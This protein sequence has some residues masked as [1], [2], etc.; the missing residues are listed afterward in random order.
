MLPTSLYGGPGTVE[1]VQLQGHCLPSP[2]D[3]VGAKLQ[4][5]TFSLEL[6]MPPW[7]LLV[8]NA[9]WNFSCIF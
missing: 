7:L 1:M 2:M 4:T 9:D 6:R 3:L 5:G 8:A